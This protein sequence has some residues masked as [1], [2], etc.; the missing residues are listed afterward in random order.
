MDRGASS[1]WHAGHYNSKPVYV[2]PYAGAAML[3][4]TATNLLFRYHPL[5]FA[6]VYTICSR[7]KLRSHSVFTVYLIRIDIYGIMAVC[8]ELKKATY[9]AFFSFHMSTFENDI[10]QAVKKR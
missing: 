3:I 2:K 7:Q 6:G 9:F 4:V 5:N 8:F 10:C 1:R